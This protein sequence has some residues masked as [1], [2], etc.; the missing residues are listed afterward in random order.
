M[1]TKMADTRNDVVLLS[2]GVE[3]H[4]AEKTPQT[5][6]PCKLPQQGGRNPW[7]SGRGAPLVARLWLNQVVQVH[8]YRQRE[9]TTQDRRISFDKL[10]FLLLEVALSGMKKSWWDLESCF[11]SG[12]PDEDAAAALCCLAFMS[13]PTKKNPQNPDLPSSSRSIWG[14]AESRLICKTISLLDG[15]MQ[16]TGHGYEEGVWFDICFYLSWCCVEVKLRA[17]GKLSILV[18]K[19]YWTWLWR[20]APSYFFLHSKK[21]KVKRAWIR[22]SLIKG[23]EQKTGRQSC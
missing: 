13:M 1:Q 16:R 4:Q 14:F 3:G 19:R 5:P 17:W 2:T 15:I 8:F 21:K 12:N 18:W 20:L 23:E 10:Q 22:A 11:E 6:T 7:V 9:I